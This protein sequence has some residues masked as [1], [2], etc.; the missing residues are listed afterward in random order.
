[1]KKVIITGANGFIGSSLTNYL[2]DMGIKVYA[3]VRDKNSN[4]ERIN[5]NENIEI[6]YCDLNEKNK[7]HE[8]I[9]DRNID[10]LYHLA[11]SGASG[12]G[13]ANYKL[14]LTNIYNSIECANQAKIMKVNK[15]I[16]VGTIGE[17]MAELALKNNIISENFIYAISKNYYHSLLDIFC[18][19]NAIQ[20]TWCTL[21]GVYGIGDNSSNI[22][23]Y[24]IHKLL[25]GVEPEYSKGDQLFDFI[26]IEDC[27]KCLYLIGKSSNSEKYYY[28]G[29][30]NPKSLR[31][32]IEIVRDVVSP[33]SNIGFGKRT[34]DGTIYKKEWFTMQ[35]TME[36]LRFIHE[37]SFVEGIKKTV[38]WVKSIKELETF[39]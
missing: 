26:Y 19:K 9:E 38:D 3:I 35:K 37:Y 36:N 2:S 17:F 21:S 39:D 23:N 28:I 4:I 18:N 14:Q 5:N 31:E 32:F 30:I 34:E 1:M 7:L 12:N 13:R 20:Y 16:T 15:F 11:W 8:I 24:T 29:G 10:V 22:I 6:K 33:N 25:Q 27:V